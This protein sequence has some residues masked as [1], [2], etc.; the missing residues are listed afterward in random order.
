MT[1]P[2]IGV[3]FVKPDTVYDPAEMIDADGST[4]LGDVDLERVACTT[5]LGLVCVKKDGR[6][7]GNICYAQGESDFTIDAG[8]L[9]EFLL[10]NVV[11]VSKGTCYSHTVT[12]I[13]WN[14][15]TLC[16]ILNSRLTVSL[17]YS[18]QSGL[19]V[20]KPMQFHEI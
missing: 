9:P 8:R 19:A 6:Q 1:S 14:L 5:D 2:D 7:D 17:C 4:T 13:S 18:L 12:V 3:V 11:D 16:G 20:Q 15:L 10:C